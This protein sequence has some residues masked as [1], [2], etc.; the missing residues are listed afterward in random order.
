MPYRHITAR[1]R[2]EFYFAPLYIIYQYVRSPF[3]SKPAHFGNLFVVA[4]F[5]VLSEKLR[6]NIRN[7]DFL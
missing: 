1:G 3:E 2:L 6:N 5:P 7:E 4:G